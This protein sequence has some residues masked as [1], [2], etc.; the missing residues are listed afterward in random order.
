MLI[1]RMEVEKFVFLY[2]GMRNICKNERGKL[3]IDTEQFPGH[4][5]MWTKSK[6]KEIVLMLYYTSCKKK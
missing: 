1:H 5:A 3:W 4:I 6:C 2:N